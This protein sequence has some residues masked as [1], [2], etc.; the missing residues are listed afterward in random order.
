MARGGLR[1]LKYGNG[2]VGLRETQSYFLMLFSPDCCFGR[3][4]RRISDKTAHTSTFDFGGLI[5]QFA[6]FV[7]EIDES[8]FPKAWCRSP[9]RS[10]GLFLGHN[11][12]V[13]EN[14]MPSSY[15]TGPMCT[16]PDPGPFAA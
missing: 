11:Q 12:M 4:Q 10:D 3:S 6:F 15:S 13:S 16:K 7:G 14:S 1:R 9:T 8:F 5:D 2:R